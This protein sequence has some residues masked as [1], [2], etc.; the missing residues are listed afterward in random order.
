M[1][2]DLTLLRRDLLDARLWT[3]AYR[4]RRTGSWRPGT[5]PGTRSGTGRRRVRRTPPPSG[6][7][8]GTRAGVYA[9]LIA[10]TAPRIERLHAEAWERKGWIMDTCL[11]RRNP[12]GR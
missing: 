4:R 10:E 2:A 11:P 9:R 12:K 6:D 1:A 3:R 8:R 7:W 5:R